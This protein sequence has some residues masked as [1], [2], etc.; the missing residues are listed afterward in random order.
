MWFTRTKEVDWEADDENE[1]PNPGRKVK[2]RYRVVVDF[3]R[4]SPAPKARSSRSSAAAKAGR[5][6]D[7]VG[8]EKQQHGEHSILPRHSCFVC[9]KTR[10]NHYHRQHPVRSG[11]N[12]IPSLCRGC[13]RDRR[14]R[15]AERHSGGRPRHRASRRLAHVDNRQ[16]C[17]NCGVLRSEHYHSLYLSGHL[18]P[19]SEICAKCRVRAEEDG[20]RKLY[21]MFLENPD[22]GGPDDD[23]DDD[24]KQVV[25]PRDSNVAACPNHLSAAGQESCD[26]GGDKGG[27]ALSESCTTPPPV[28]TGRLGNLNSIDVKH[29]PSIQPAKPGDCSSTPKLSK[30]RPQDPFVQPSTRKTT[31]EDENVMEDNSN[32]KNTNSK[33]AKAENRESRQH[34]QKAQHE[35]H[36]QRGPA[37]KPARPGH[38]HPPVTPPITTPTATHKGRGHE[39][40]Q[41]RREKTPTETQT[42][43]RKQPRP[44]SRSRESGAAGTGRKS[45]PQ[46][47]GMGISDMYWASEHGRFERAFSSRSSSGA[48]GG[49]GGATAFTSAA[50]GAFRPGAHDSDD[51]NWCGHA[52]PSSCG[53]GGDYSYYY[54]NYSY[55]PHRHHYYAYS[56]PYSYPQQQQQQRDG[57]A[58]PGASMGYSSPAKHHQHHR[59]YDQQQD[60]GVG[61]MY[62]SRHDHNQNQNQSQSQSQVWEVDSDEADEIDRAHAGLVAA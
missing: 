35:K 13:R 52:C 9:G 62:W 57:Y 5:E 6:E 59:Y 56:Y 41:R 3:G 24:W 34:Q 16:W 45:R 32:S 26:K 31:V 4:G 46:R 39:E 21:R 47:I 19:W 10:S 25:L 30:K 11:E 22:V 1:E 43:R 18:P 38:T 28:D 17:A 44:Q 40:R 37:D 23:D 42:P 33:P 7:P 50:A 58:V 54:Y 8:S 20:R 61:H 36:G 55:H 48:G 12:P 60:E 53:N 51:S 15:I 14:A 2:K 49:A 29:H 27:S